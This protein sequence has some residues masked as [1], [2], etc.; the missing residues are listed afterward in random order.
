MRAEII[1]RAADLAVTHGTDVEAALGLWQAAGAFEGG[2]NAQAWLSVA[3]LYS[4]H[5]RFAE[6][7][8]RR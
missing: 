2:R 5:N 6:A 7:P 8:F 3:F 1:S 4:R